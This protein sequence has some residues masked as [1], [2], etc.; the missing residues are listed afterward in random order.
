VHP[1]T[2]ARIKEVA[3]ALGYG[4]WPK[5]SNKGQEPHHF[6]ALAQTRRSGSK[7]GY[8]AGISKASVAL[9]ACILSHHVPAEECEKVLDRAFQPIAMS[10]GM[11]EG[12]VLIHHWP[13]EVACRLAAKWPTV[14]IIHH[15]PNSPIDHIG[16]DERAGMRLLI[17]HLQAVGRRRIGFFGYCPTISWASSRYAAYI[18]ALLSR[19]LRFDP[20][21]TVRL[22]SDEAMSPELLA[23]GPWADAIVEKSK[24]SVNA[25]VCSSESIGY[26]LLR[27]LME[28]G[29]RV[30]EQV[31]IT[32]FHAGMTS[33]SGLPDLTSI[34]VPDEELGAAA[35]RRLVYRINHRDESTRSIL[36]PGWFVQGKTTPSKKGV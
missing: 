6:M 9:N 4:A 2:R 8:L 3:D 12:L 33:H 14:S 30:P 36:I 34:N 19:E 27:F 5:K 29:I 18:E 13:I 17:E 24:T 20:D 28:R 23:P 15:Y 22:G 7:D 16:I 21:L 32:G 11:V 31:A 25:W 35:G 26:S 1:A 10:T